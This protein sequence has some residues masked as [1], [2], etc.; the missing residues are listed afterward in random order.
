[1][2]VLKSLAFDEICQRRSIRQRDVTALRGLLLNNDIV[3]QDEIAGLLEINRACTIQDETWSDFLSDAVADFAIR[4][5]EP[6]GYVTSEKAAW[7]IKAMAPAGRV[8]TRTLLRILPKLLMHARWVPVSLTLFAIEQV[9]LAV[10]DGRGPLR[11]APN[12]GSNALLESDADFVASIIGTQRSD[13]PVL[14]STAELEAL[15]ATDCLAETVA[16]AWTALLQTLVAA[17]ALRASGWQTA[18]R[19]AL[20]NAPVWA[21]DPGPADA[22][23]RILFGTGEPQP[24][25][26]AER[27]PELVRLERQ[28][29]EIITGEPLHELCPRSLAAYLSTARPELSHGLLRV[30]DAGVRLDGAFGPVVASLSG[31]DDR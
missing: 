30:V 22:Y 29:I 26:K 6:S 4:D 17:A 5:L 31:L 16:P 25:P 18:S 20:L 12:T 10:Q 28:R 8:E 11:I 19:Y 3:T 15:I 9:R 23:A 24:L 14:I 13:R 7:L 1:M 27:E 2:S 21:D